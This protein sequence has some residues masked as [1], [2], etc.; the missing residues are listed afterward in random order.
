[1]IKL[2]FVFQYEWFFHTC[3]TVHKVSIIYWYRREVCLLVWNENFSRAKSWSIN[4]K[5]KRND[6]F[7][8]MISISL[9]TFTPRLSKFSNDILSSYKTYIHIYVSVIVKMA[10]FMNL[11]MLRFALHLF[12]LQQSEKYHF[13][14]LVEIDP[15]VVDIELVVALFNEIR[16]MRQTQNIE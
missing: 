7:L 9:I 13:C 16:L 3:K 1:M 4:K 12:I 6:E 10:Q 14:K 5:I 15:L 11:K 8:Q 2:I